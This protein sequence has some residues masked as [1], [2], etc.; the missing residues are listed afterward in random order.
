[1]TAKQNRC[2]FTW[3]PSRIC[4]KT[5]TLRPIRA[6]ADKALA[7]LDREFEAMYSSTGRPSIPPEQLL[8]ALRLQA[9]YTIRSNRLLVEQVS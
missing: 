9:L 1:M 2:S 8:K 3:L 4:Q 6:L 5:T 7:E